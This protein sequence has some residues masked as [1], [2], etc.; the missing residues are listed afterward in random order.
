MEV[1][2]RIPE[3][4]FEGNVNL[5]GFVNVLD[6]LHKYKGVAINNHSFYYKSLLSF[7]KSWLKKR[8]EDYGY[9]EIP[10][11]LPKESMEA[12]LINSRNVMYLKGSDLGLKFFLWSLTFGDVDI[13]WEE[14]YPQGDILFLSEYAG[15]GHLLADEPDTTDFVNYLT[16][17][18][19]DVG[20]Q[21]LTISIATPYWN[22]SI[23]ENYIRDNIR[24]FINFTDDSFVLNLELTQGPHVVIPEPYWYFVNGH[25]LSAEIVETIPGIP[26]MIIGSDFIVT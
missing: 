4:F 18:E 9:P 8:L 12:L 26:E 25:Q 20:N 2:K 19:E 7:E 17:N 15:R 14:F 16:S 23:V 10:I 11:D 13:D 22:N 21:V 24:N 3:K 6:A 5:N 1:R